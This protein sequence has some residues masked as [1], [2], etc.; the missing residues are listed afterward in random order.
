MSFWDEV[1]S[2]SS[3]LHQGDYLPGCYVA[4]PPDNYAEPV[5]SA[6][7]NLVEG[8]AED[9][10]LTNEDGVGRSIEIV[11]KSLLVVTQSC[12][13]LGE[14]PVRLWPVAGGTQ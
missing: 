8:A 10:A 5:A 11:L 12:D 7:S 6:E 4:V 13:L 3:E 14:S 2:G 9:E 1:A